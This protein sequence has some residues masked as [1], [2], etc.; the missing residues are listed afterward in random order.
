LR[1]TGLVLPFVALQ[2]VAS[3]Q[4][5]GRIWQWPLQGID[6]AVGKGYTGVY[7]MHNKLGSTQGGELAL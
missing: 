4:R 7:T 2:E 3:C 5:A 6:D 1:P